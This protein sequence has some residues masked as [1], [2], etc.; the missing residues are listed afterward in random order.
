[1]ARIPLASACTTLA[2]LVGLQTAAL[3][4]HTHNHHTHRTTLLDRVRRSLLGDEEP[5]PAAA[6]TARAPS[7][8]RMDGAS[9]PRMTRQSAVKAQGKAKSPSST[10]STS[11]AKAAKP[12][13]STAPSRSAQSSNSSRRSLATDAD[14]TPAELPDATE[15]DFAIEPQPL[16][17]DGDEAVTETSDEPTA[18]EADGEGAPRVARA[19]K[20]TAGPMRPDPTMLFSRSTPLVTVRGSGPRRMGVG[21]VAE[22]RVVVMNEGKQ[23]A[24]DVAVH[25]SLPAAIE[26]QSTKA[27]SGAVE[28][29]SEGAL[30]WTLRTLAPDNEEECVLRIS[31]RDN[32]PFDFDVKLDAAPVVVKTTVE[33]EEAQLAL[34]IDG[35]SQVLAGS[36][37]VY[38]LTVSN[39]GNGAAENVVVHLLP[40]SP[41]EGEVSS[42]RIG[43]VGAGES[44]VVEIELAARQ[45]GQL[46]IQAK[47]T[48]D[49]D[50]KA[51]AVEEVTVRQPGL[52]IEVVGP[53]RQYAGAA[54]TYQVHLRNPG[55]APARRVKVTA[56]LPEKAEY[57]AAS[58]DGK[59]DAKHNRAV[60]S[61][62]SLAPGVEQIFT[63]KCIVHAGGENRIE[64]TALADGDLR[65]S[66][67]ALT[68][69][70]AV[71]DL[72]LDV[73]D[74][75]GAIAVGEDALYEVRIRNRGDKAAEGIDVVAFFSKGIEPV[76]VDGGAFA[77]TPGTVSFDTIP[78]LAPGKELVFKVHAKAET[79]GTH[80]F[81]V[82]LQCKSVSTKLTQ[83]ETTLFYGDE[84]APEVHAEA[85][86]TEEAPQAAQ[87]PAIR[88][89][90][91]ATPR[92]GT[93]LR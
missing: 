33:V 32:R 83:E 34:A 6:K 87:A 93:E 8:A 5:T 84:L 65:H 2:V 39:L 56:E 70:L 4:Q 92:Q 58:H 69:V 85:P 22:Y 37:E 75:S 80:R 21:E 44:K 79:S 15:G 14:P 68:E 27:T 66:N 71:A 3:A 67:V 82:E 78:T 64:A 59:F 24:S 16:I 63:V 30:Q 89:P 26:V 23:P 7:S 52:H 13:R 47:A 81:R 62:A 18:L 43:T 17:A 61:V 20:R 60:W 10:W 42:H 35:P 45:G 25:V 29:A 28:P 53:A 31:A 46:N 90:R 19:E 49:G 55:D 11:T 40:L 36:K 51:S 72:V 57:V 91:L 86:T 12:R 73:S 38:R 9:K 76:T 50:L 88:A 54:A 1:M 41:G 74:P 48:G 77:L